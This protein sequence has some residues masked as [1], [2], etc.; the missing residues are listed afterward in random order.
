MARKIIQRFLPDPNWIKRHRSLRLLGAWIHDPN[1][2]HLNR[3]SVALATFIGL[4][5]AFIPLPGQMIFAAFLAVF[6]RANLPISVCLV[7][8]TNPITIAPIFYFCYKVGALILETPAGEFD[9]E[10]SWQWIS[11]ELSTSWQPFLLGC[12]INGIFFGLLGSAT[13]RWLWRRHTLSRWRERNLKR[14]GK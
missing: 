13:T 10:I 9:F 2:W 12:F 11:Q 1:L 6:F 4:F 5:C 8:V 14:Q 3:Q 7:W